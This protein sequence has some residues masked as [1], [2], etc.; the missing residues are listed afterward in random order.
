M[1]QKVHTQ[2]PIQVQSVAIFSA[3]KLLTVTNIHSL[4]RRNLK[5]SSTISIRTKLITAPRIQFTFASNVSELG[6]F[7]RL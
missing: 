7:V 2:N 4:L 5:Q 6:N 1:N 3:W